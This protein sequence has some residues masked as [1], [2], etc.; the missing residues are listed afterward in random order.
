MSDDLLSKY[1][2]KRAGK[3]PATASRA[4]LVVDHKPQAPNASGAYAAYEAFGNEVRAVSV[5]IRCNR[6]DFAYFMPYAHMGVVVFN[7]RTGTEI[8][9]TCGGYAVTILGRHLRGIVLALRLHSCSSIQ[10]FVPEEFVRPEPTADEVP[11]VD[12][13]VVQVLSPTGRKKEGAREQEAE[14]A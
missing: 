5:E 13:I 3:A 8:F 7:H 11:F 12:S 1:I 4:E 6:T 14:E 9:F 10:D 2:D